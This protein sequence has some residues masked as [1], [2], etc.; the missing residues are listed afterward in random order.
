MPVARWAAIG[1]AWRYFEQFASCY[2]LPLFYL[3][4]YPARKAEFTFLYAGVNMFC[5]LISS[6]LGGIICDRFGKGNPRM[7]A[8][9]CMAGNIL[10]LPLLIGS[11]LITNNFYLSMALTAG[12]YLIG[13]HYRSPALTMVQNTTP[14]DKQ[15]SMVGA[16]QFANK[17]FSVFS[18][19]I[20]QGAF[21][22]LPVNGNPVLLGRILA[23]ICTFA[24]GISTFSYYKAGE[25]Y[26]K[27]MAND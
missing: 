23:A 16:Y 7:K 26:A 18:A 2:Y 10:C 25:S 12:R 17:M 9:V 6:L 20:I 15:G 1:S 21:V 5:G 8:Q 3:T 11:V 13:E 14:P 27:I 19:I 24:V 4:C 22:Y